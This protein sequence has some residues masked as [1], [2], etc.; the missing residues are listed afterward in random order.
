MLTNFWLYSFF[1]LLNLWLTFNWLLCLHILSSF[2]YYL[3]FYWLFLASWD[4]PKIWLL[5]FSMPSFLLYSFRAI[6]TT[7]AI[8][9]DLS[10][11]I[12]NTV[13]WKILL[14]FYCMS[15]L[16]VWYFKGVNLQIFENFT[17]ISLVL[18]AMLIPL[19]EGNTILYICCFQ[20][21][22]NS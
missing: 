7:A 20:M 18:C 12:F 13:Q 14:K 17:L 16:L 11:H 6:S 21:R 10:L 3:C 22:C 8:S 5:N 1:F 2:I 15:F 4:L 9:Q 19:S